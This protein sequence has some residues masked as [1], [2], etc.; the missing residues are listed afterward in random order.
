MYEI[1]KEK[2]VSMSLRSG[3]AEFE[4]GAIINLYYL[5]DNFGKD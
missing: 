2:L 1:E 3:R 4:K 5:S